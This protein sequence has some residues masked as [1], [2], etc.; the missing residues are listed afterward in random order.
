MRHHHRHHGNTPEWARHEFGH[1]FTVLD[2]IEDRLDELMALLPGPAVR[3]SISFDQG[4][5]MPDISVQDDHAP[6]TGTV[7]FKDAKGAVTQAEGKPTWASSD[8]SVASVS[9]SDDGLTATV[10]VGNPGAAVISCDSIDADGTD[11]AAA[12]TVTVTSG[13]PATGDISLA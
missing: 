4:G 6:L 2:E 8:E 9:A 3:A 5:T 1:V 11:I 13:P 10:T 12:A 7:E